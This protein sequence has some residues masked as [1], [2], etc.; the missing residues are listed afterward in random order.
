[1]GGLCLRYRLGL[2]WWRSANCVDTAHSCRERRRRRRFPAARVWSPIKRLSLT[3][4]PPATPSLTLTSPIESHSLCLASISKNW[5]RTGR[6]LTADTEVKQYTIYNLGHDRFVAKKLSCRS[7]SLCRLKFSLS[8][9]VKLEGH[10]VERMHL[11][12]RCLDGAVKLLQN[13]VDSFCS[14]SQVN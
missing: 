6:L 12:Q 8:F 1:M 4:P 5:I 13:V 7:V 11:R 9:N 2:R 10:S 14:T 3:R